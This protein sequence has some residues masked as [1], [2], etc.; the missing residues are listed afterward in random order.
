[1]LSR[2]EICT[3]RLE[4]RRRD[5]LHDEYID[6]IHGDQDDCLPPET[7]N[8]IAATIISFNLIYKKN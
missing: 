8:I 1:M 7:V 4:V 3:K 6:P 2:N 5:S